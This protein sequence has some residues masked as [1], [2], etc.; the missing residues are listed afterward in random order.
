LFDH[1]R[2]AGEVR[3]HLFLVDAAEDGNV[4]GGGPSDAREQTDQGGFARSVLSDESDQL[5]FF[6]VQSDIVK[7]QTASI[8]LA[9]MFGRD[10]HI[11]GGKLF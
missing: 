7:G 10:D 11:A 1:G 5:A 9:E 2:D 4:S 8:L 6:D 3:F